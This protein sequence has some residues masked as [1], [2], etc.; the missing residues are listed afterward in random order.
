MGANFSQSKLYLYWNGMVDFVPHPEIK[1]IQYDDFAHKASQIIA[2]PCS[3]TPLSGRYLHEK[4]GYKNF[5]DSVAESFSAEYGS[6]PH[7]VALN[8]D[9]SFDWKLE[10]GKQLS[11]NPMGL[12]GFMD[13]YH[14]IH[15]ATLYPSQE[16]CEMWEAVANV[17]KEQLIIAQAYEMMYQ[18]LTRSAV[19][20]GDLECKKSLVFIVLD[21]QAADYLCDVFGAEK[22]AEVLPVP[23]LTNYTKPTRKVRSDKKPPLSIDE[24]RAKAAAKKRDQRA[25]AKMAK[26]QI[27]ASA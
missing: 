20:D 18:F 21:R 9:Q 13:R 15:L 27:A 8:A 25:A 23:A 22:G 16:D 10:N 1:G 19:R 5:C 14:A 11:A 12:N 2:R 26:T 17:S 6:V 3:E 4:I 24:I 7:L